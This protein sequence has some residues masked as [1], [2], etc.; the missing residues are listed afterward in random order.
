[1]ELQKTQFCPPGKLEVWLKEG[2]TRPR[3][4]WLSEEEQFIH[5]KIM[6]E[7]GYEAPLNWYKSVIANTDAPNWSRIS[8]K[9]LILRQ[10]VV[11]VGGNLD[12]ITRP[13]SV[14]VAA[15]EGQKQGF[16]LD[17]QVKYLDAG[18]WLQL[19]KRQEVSN[20]LKELAQRLLYCRL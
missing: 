20:I 6:L 17:V 1:V 3:P 12:P 5:S 14:G 19:E 16:L 8:P 7:G 2:E 15:E 11:F 13:E 4:A 10:P 9:G 18:H